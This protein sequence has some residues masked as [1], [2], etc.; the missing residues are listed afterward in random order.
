M[1]SNKPYREEDKFDRKDNGSRYISHSYRRVSESGFEDSTGKFVLDKEVFPKIF[2]EILRPEYS[3]GCTRYFRVIPIEQLKR[4][5]I[6]QIDWEFILNQM[7]LNE[8]YKGDLELLQFQYHNHEA[9]NLLEGSVL[10]YDTLKK[11][12]N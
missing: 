11:L 1:L 8:Y 5:Y 12:K 6:Y 9:Y 4:N 10:K 2:K 3:L 7:I